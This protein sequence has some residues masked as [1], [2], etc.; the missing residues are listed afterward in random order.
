MKKI[1]STFTIVCYIILVAAVLTWFIPGGEYLRE[2]QTV[3]GVTRSVVVDDSFHYVE[4]APQTYSVLFA[5]FKGFVD[6]AD[7]IVFV[8]MVGGAFWILNSTKAIDK[9]VQS[10][11]RFTQACRRKKWLR[12]ID[13]DLVVLAFISVMF[14]LFGA[15]FGMS[16][17]TIAFI[18][19]FVPMAVSM[20][21]DS[22]TGVCISYLAAHVGFAGAMLNPFTI[23]IAQGIAGIP[24]FSGLGYRV[25]CWAVLT[26]IAL[27]FILWYARRV[28]RDPQK[29]PVHKIDE[30]WRRRAREEKE[31]EAEK[32]SVPR[33]LYAVFVFLC[34][35]Q[36]YFACRF[37]FTQIEI[38]TQAVRL[39]ILPVL[40]G[41][42]LLWGA[43]SCRKSV[44]AFNLQL[45]FFTVFY[46]VIG[47]LGY[48]WYIMEISALFLAMG[49]CA[50]LAAGKGLDKVMGLFLEGVKD[51]LV[52][53]MVIGLASGIIF[54][55]QEG[56][57]ID[58]M[59]HGV[60]SAM[61]R[62]GETASV[63]V[64]YAFQTLLNVVMPSG[65]AKAALTMP[66]MSQFADLIHI[67]R[68]TTVL[69][70][71]FGDGFTNMLTP[72]SGI[73]LGVLGVARIPYA[74]WFRWVWKFILFL[75]C[76]GFLLIIPTLFF[77]F[78]GF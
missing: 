66:I 24:L 48:Q 7:I 46:L 51:I 6:K 32:T 59:L 39:C 28:K 75:I 30:Y 77:D 64:M 61:S 17:E 22:L 44:A 53:A 36:V 42:F 60:A 58:T 72:T 41:L 50:G 56:K 55:L 34:A 68:Q 11:V 71:Q 52:P 25:F 2:S 69:A 13:I 21:Y 70:F 1:P 76:V 57:V 3:N 16:E 8:L 19:V 47:V 14:S 43:F 33:T 78:A 26:A 49:L 4:P 35:V 54:V 20:G 37:P 29:S 73:L 5:L 63:G 31:Q 74:L 40:A 62:M 27:V 12:K 65:S 45:L 38:G 9:G 10:F 23:G 15:V 18:I 67:S